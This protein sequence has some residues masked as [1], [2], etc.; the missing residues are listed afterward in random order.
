LSEVPL[1]RF[2]VQNSG[3]RGETRDDGPERG[4]VRR[5]VVVERV[6]LQGCE[7]SNK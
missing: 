4:V 5:V 6:A 3:C 7:M 2:R 1:H